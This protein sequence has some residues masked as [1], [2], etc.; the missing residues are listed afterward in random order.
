MPI[1]VAE[2][3]EGWVGDYSLGGIAGPNPV[4]GTDVC[5]WRVLCVVKQRSL[6]R[7][8]PSSR[9]VCV[10]VCVRFSVIRCNSNPSHLV[11]RGVTEENNLTDSTS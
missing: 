5:P 8:D 6:R 10:C 2:R 3:S 4:G 7:A 1:S 9:G 11:Q